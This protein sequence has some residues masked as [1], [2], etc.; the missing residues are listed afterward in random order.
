M[1]EDIVNGLI[2][3]GIL[4]NN[5]T[6]QVGKNELLLMWKE[7][8]QMKPLCDH[9]FNSLSRKVNNEQNI[10]IVRKSHKRR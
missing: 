3:E 4:K 6:K 10:A 9:C 2:K 5:E 7:N 8:C 1:Q